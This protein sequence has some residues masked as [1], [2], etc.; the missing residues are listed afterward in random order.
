MKTITINKNKIGEDLIDLVTDYLKH[1]KVAI[2]P[3]DTIYGLHCLATDRKAI[4]KIYKIKQRSTRKPLLILVSSLTMLKRYCYIS[5]RQY[6]YLQTIWPAFA[7]PLAKS[8][9]TAG[10]PVDKLNLVAGF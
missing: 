7:P 10:K 8:G 5:K 2:L 3:T 9:A 1:G 4:Q 6:E